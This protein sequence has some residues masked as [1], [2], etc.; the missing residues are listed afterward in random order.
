MK[1]HQST[2]SKIFNSNVF[3]LA[4]CITHTLCSLQMEDVLCQSIQ[5]FHHNKG[6]HWEEVYHEYHTQWWEQGGQL[7]H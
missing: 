7:I 5:C 1:H 4:T 2:M 3:F 6:T